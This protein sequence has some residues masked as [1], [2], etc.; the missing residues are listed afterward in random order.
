MNR[1]QSMTSAEYRA[2]KAKGGKG[3]PY[4]PRAKL[5]D[6]SMDGIPFASKAELR[7]YVELKHLRSTGEVRYFLLQP[8]FHVLGVRVRADFQI[9]W[10]SGEVTYED[11]KGSGGHPEHARRS[12]RNRKQVWEAF[13]VEIEIVEQ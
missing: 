9:F 5:D 6:R 12:E 11:A 8:T 2:L 4:V 1:S 7:R 13:G 3:K 10:T